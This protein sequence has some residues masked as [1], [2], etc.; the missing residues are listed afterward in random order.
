MSISDR[1]K[2]LALTNVA[3]TASSSNDKTSVKVP[4]KVTGENW[5]SWEQEMIPILGSRECLDENKP[6]NVGRG[7]VLL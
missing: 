3:L 6:R 1:L 2:V 5:I 7:E 4:L